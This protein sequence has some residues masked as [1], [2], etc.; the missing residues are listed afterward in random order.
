VV[1]VAGI[2]VITDK[3]GVS[4]ACIMC[5]GTGLDAVSTGAPIP[6]TMFTDGRRTVPTGA[7]C[8]ACKGHGREPG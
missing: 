6:G 2:I 3:P 5:G 4:P 8:R 1:T 7:K